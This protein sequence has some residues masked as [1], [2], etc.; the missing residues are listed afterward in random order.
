MVRINKVSLICDIDKIMVEYFTTK[1]SLKASI[2]SKLVKKESP[3]ILV[4]C[5]AAPSNMLNKKNRAIL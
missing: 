2:L 4:S 1:E 5:K 3:Y